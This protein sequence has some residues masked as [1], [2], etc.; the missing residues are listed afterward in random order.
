[1]T[2]KLGIVVHRRQRLG[3]RDNEGEGQDNGNDRRQNHRRELGE[4]ADRLAAV[5]DQV[6]A[7]QHL[8][9][10]ND[11]QNGQERHEKH[12]ADAP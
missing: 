12:L 9:R 7:L 2:V 6:D 4:R 3:D 5:G 8:S 11:R 10:P 1:M